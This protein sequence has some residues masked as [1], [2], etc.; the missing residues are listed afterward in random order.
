MIGNHDDYFDSF[1]LPSEAANMGRVRDR[2]L[3]AE[4]GHAID[5]FN[6]KSG[7]PGRQWG[8]SITQLATWKPIVRDWEDPLAG[9]VAYCTRSYPARL[10][11][12]ERACRLSVLDPRT[13][14]HSM[15]AMGH[16]H[17]P[18]VKLIHVRDGD[19]DGRE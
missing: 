1:L 10:S 9:T 6:N 13:W 11:Y 18:C 8:H 12:L 16:T 7:S 15:F 19:P 2:G 17:R 14:T 4:H 3:Y 5:G